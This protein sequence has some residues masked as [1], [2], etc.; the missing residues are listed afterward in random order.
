M[1]EGGGGGRWRESKGTL[2]T[3]QGKRRQIHL[4]DKRQTDGM[5]YGATNGRRCFATVTNGFTVLY[6]GGDAVH[7]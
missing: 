2:S 6:V 1:R 5:S 7:P 4:D 3:T